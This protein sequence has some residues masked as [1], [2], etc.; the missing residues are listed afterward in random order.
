MNNK[1]HVG[2]DP[3]KD[4]A[5]VA[6]NQDGTIEKMLFPFIGDEYDIKGMSDIFY[7]LTRNK[8]IHIVIEDV[9]ALQRQFDRGNWSLSG[10]KHILLTLVT[11]HQIPFTLVTPKTWQKIIW[12]GINE[13]RKPS[14][15]DA[16]GNI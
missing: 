16:K 5:I 3:G 6:I 9:K 8:N 4:G 2:C 13:H 14:T 10:C 15:T 11:I 12:Q 1:I 7:R